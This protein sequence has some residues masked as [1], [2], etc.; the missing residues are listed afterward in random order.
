MIFEVNRQVIQKCR[1]SKLEVQEL[2]VTRS[3][4]DRLVEAFRKA[5]EP[6]P[7]AIIVNNLDSRIQDT[8]GAIISDINFA[9]EIL[10]D[11]GI[12]FIFWLSEK[13]MALVANKAT[14]LYIRRDRSVIRFPDSFKRKELELTI[15]LDKIEGIPL[16]ELKQ[17]NL[18]IQLLEK[19]LKE[20]TKKQFSEKRIAAEIIFDLVTACLE[21]N[22]IG[23][24]AAYFSRYND[25]FE[26]SD[27]LD[28]LELTAMI[29]FKT[30]QFDLADNYYR[31]VKAIQRETGDLDGLASTFHQLGF[32]AQKRRNFETA[33]RWNQKAL[34]IKEK[35]GDKHGSAIIYDHLGMIAH[36]QND[37]ETAEKWYQKSLKINETQGDEHGAATAY[38]HLGM[39]AQRQRDFE[40]ADKWFQ[41]SLM[42]KETQGDEYGASAAYHHLGIN[43]QKQRNF[44]TAKTWFLKSLMIKEKQGNEHGIALTNLALGIL[45]SKEKKDVESSKQIIKGIILLKKS[46]DD[47]RL[48]F[49][50]QFFLDLYGQ[51]PHPIQEEL[52]K[53]WEQAGLGDFPPEEK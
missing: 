27:R 17:L 45:L 5:A 12:C 28:Y 49:A 25:F 9:R 6:S 48:N 11:L 13:N 21:A 30:R 26:N 38:H 32:I 37:L 20:A 14:D 8:D 41:K 22:D 3:K 18:K 40:T 31:R 50:I 46:V 15:P 43:A 10:I 23:K 1:D 16:T 51:Q 2:S 34:R 47:S 24:A 4:A 44:K 53:E 35:L 39:I 19:H 36:K 7:K 52:R 29:L 33:E 42:I